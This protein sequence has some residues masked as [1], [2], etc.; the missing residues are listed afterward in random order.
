MRARWRVWCRRLR[1]LGGA[2][3]HGEHDTPAI[4]EAILFQESFLIL[5]TA[6]RALRTRVDAQTRRRRALWSFM[7][8]LD[9]KIQND[10]APASDAFP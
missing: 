8:A 9:G 5:G 3:L 2:G 6:D 1:R 7:K 4:R 10:D